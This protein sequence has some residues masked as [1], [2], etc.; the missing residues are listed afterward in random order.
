MNNL[1]EMIKLV[2]SIPMLYVFATASRLAPNTMA[3]NVLTDDRN[4]VD[5]IE[6]YD[7]IPIHKS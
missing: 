4:N 3:E 1:D 7:L 2:N 5:V 6:S